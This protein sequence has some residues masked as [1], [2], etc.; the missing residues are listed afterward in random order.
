MGRLESWNGERIVGA[1]IESAGRS[2][3]RVIEERCVP[4]A[5][6]ETP[7]DTGTARDSV[8]HEGG[9]VWGYHVRYGIFIE[10]GAEGRSGHHAL[11]RAADTHYPELAPMI[12]DD[13]RAR[14]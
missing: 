6:A 5:K 2:R 11:R 1:I 7:V 14:L 8:R 12:A 10:V 13:W 3:D 9:G 4:D